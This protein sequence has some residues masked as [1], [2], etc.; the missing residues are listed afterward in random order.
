MSVEVIDMMERIYGTEALKIFVELNIF[1]YR[2]RIG[3][4]DDPEKEMKKI[5]HYEEILAK[6]NI[7]TLRT[8]KD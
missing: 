8:E 6:L 3:H 4:K 1:K 5:R 7:K 2:M